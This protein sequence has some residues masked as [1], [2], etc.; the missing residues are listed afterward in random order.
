MVLIGQISNG[1]F[2]VG[3][4]LGGVRGGARWAVEFGKGRGLFSVSVSA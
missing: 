4:P 2:Q 1:D 3:I